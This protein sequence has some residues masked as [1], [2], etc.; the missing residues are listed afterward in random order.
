MKIPIYID[1]P[2]AVEATEAFKRNSSSFDDE[3]RELVL[4][5]IIPLSLKT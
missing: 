1:S 2:M 4:R 3:A 5:E